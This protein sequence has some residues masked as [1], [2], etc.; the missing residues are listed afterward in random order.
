[1]PGQT[2]KGGGLAG[3]LNNVDGL[4]P[5]EEDAGERP[6]V[7]ARA[8]PSTGAPTSSAALHV[9]PPTQPVQQSGATED[10]AVAAAEPVDQ[11]SATVEVLAEER[12]ID[13]TSVTPS[14]SAPLHRPAPT[15]AP[16]PTV[17]R[18]APRAASAPYPAA[19]PAPQRPAAQAPQRTPAPMGEYGQD[20][21][22]PPRRNNRPGRNAI[23]DRKEVFLWPDQ[24]DE[25]RWLARQLNQI[26]CGQG[27]RITENTLIRVA[28][29]L[30]LKNSGNIYGMTER[31]LLASL[32][33]PDR[34]E[35]G[36]FPA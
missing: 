9:V 4:L 29:D 33:L 25:V 3:L 36:L 26:R 20:P 32:G 34:D 7:P 27:E 6:A 24:Y 10:A 8:E 23:R 16:A 19:R 15:R 14:S 12:G 30:L 28:I 22:L 35:N 2:R 13:L 1:M 17:T 31:E 11:G 5:A 21:S 18:A